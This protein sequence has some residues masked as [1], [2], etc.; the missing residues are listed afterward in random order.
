MRGTNA[1]EIDS[2]ARAVKGDGSRMAGIRVIGL[3]QEEEW[4]RIIAQFEQHDV[5]Y[6]PGYVRAFER[7][8]DGEPLL[9]FYNG[10][11][12]QAVNVVMRRPVPVLR[13]L[14]PDDEALKAYFDLSLTVIIRSSAMRMRWSACMRLWT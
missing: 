2:N 7:N 6:T 8:G 4:L 12:M 3:E 13:T 5:Y 11:R 1:W 14:T 10:K 9:L